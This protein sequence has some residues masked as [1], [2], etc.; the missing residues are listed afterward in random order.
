[1]TLVNR[2]L[3]IIFLLII[4]S[5]Q[6]RTYKTFFIK[7][8]AQGTTYSIKYNTNQNIITKESV[9]SLLDVIDLSMSTYVSNS[10]ISK[11]NNNIDV[12]LD[13][14][15]YYVLSK[16]IDL[17]YQTHGMF[18]VTV[19]PIVSDWGF[20]PSKKRKDSDNLDNSLYQVG[21]DKILLEGNKLI[22]QP[23]VKIDLNGIAQGFT[24]DYIADY[25]KYHDVSDFMIEVGGEVICSGNNL[26][27]QWKIGV[28]APNNRDDPFAYVLKLTDMALATSGSYR[29]FYYLDSTK[30]SHTIHPKKLRPVNNQLISAT[31][32]HKDCMS[33]DAYATACMSFGLDSARYF[34]TNNNI[35][36][37]LIYLEGGD[38]LYYFSEGFSSFL[39]RSP[40]SAPQ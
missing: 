17:C 3:F 21:C 33:A 20:G 19:S 30:I 9:D 8:Y 37:S 26:D 24:V 29:N 40:G 25:F 11:I 18:D 7:G 27:N 32:L 10:T 22:K 28:D 39:H 16:S 35:L 1:M 13:S 38:T 12:S 14:L 6:E 23:L 2:F 4:T 36:G 5:C 31:I 15:I 34:L